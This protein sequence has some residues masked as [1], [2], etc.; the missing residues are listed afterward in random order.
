MILLPI[1]Y[2]LATHGAASLLPQLAALAPVLLHRCSPNP[3]K[4]ALCP[5]LLVF[6]SRR[7]FLRLNAAASA[8]PAAGTEECALGGCGWAN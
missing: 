2:V 3:A 8:G 4:F 7:P 5:K 1:Q 6:N